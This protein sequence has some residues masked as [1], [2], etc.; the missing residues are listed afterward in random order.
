MLLTVEVL[1]IKKHGKYIGMGIFPTETI[2]Y[3]Y[4]AVHKCVLQAIPNRKEE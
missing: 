4:G 3:R 1:I 2:S